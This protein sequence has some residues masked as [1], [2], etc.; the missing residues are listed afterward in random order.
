MSGIT[1]SGVVRDEQHL[2]TL[3]NLGSV[4]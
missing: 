3:L 2:K 4:A 1:E